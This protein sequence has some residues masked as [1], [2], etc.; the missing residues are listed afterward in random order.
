MSVYAAPYISEIR[1]AVARRHT[2]QELRSIFIRGT[3]HEVPVDANLRQ[4]V[5][6]WHAHQQAINAGATPS[7]FWKKAVGLNS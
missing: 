3:G 2:R 7:A 5:S 4:Y 1:L 6:K